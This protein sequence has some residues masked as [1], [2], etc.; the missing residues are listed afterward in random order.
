MRPVEQRETIAHRTR[1]VAALI[2]S[3]IIAMSLLLLLL[4]R[5][6]RDQGEYH[7]CHD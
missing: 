4:L 5:D 1:L 3:D 7:G 2:E 6:Q